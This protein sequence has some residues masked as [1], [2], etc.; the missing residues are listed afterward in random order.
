M[1]KNST[2][3]WCRIG[4]V[5][6]LLS[7][8][9]SYGQDPDPRLYVRAAPAGGYG[10]TWEP[11]VPVV[12]WVEPRSEP[13][14]PLVETMA[15]ADAA[16]QPQPIVAVGQ[17][18]AHVV[19]RD[20]VLAFER[21]QPGRAPQW[22]PH[23]DREAIE[24]LLL[25]RADFAVVGTKLSE[26]ERQAGLRE[27][28]LGVELFALAVAPDSPVRSLTQF[29]VRQIFTAQV[30]DWK[31]LGFP[32]GPIVAI[33]PSDPAKAER[34][35]RVLMPGDVF[36]EPVA[37]VA[38]T[39]HVADRLLHDPTGIGIVTIDA[40]KVSGLQLVAIDWTP[41][42]PEAYEYGTY[43]FG[44]PVHLVT[45]GEPAGEA[46]RFLTFL[47]GTARERLTAKLCLP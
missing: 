9:C 6:L 33:A 37:R 41:P 25:G 43:P 11:P 14:A 22:L 34:A 36:A 29:Q 30:A 46:Q 24:L 15:A 5:G 44:V 45:A 16:P 42:T 21:Q 7:T 27:T 10:R 12:A 32:A 23:P 2:P 35:A 1:G 8:G 19:D 28:R 3:A 13:A 40:D 47:R 31:Q 20:L 17:H 38:S 18:A 39:R 4:I 26:R